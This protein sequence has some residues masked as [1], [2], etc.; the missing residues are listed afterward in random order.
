MSNLFLKLFSFPQKKKAK[1]NV[2][3]LTCISVKEA[4]VVASSFPN[5]DLIK[6]KERWR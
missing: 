3:F 4:E 1:F 6:L 2:K 5:L